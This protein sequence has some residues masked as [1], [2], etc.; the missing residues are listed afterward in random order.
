[1]KKNPNHLFYLFIILWL[2]LVPGCFKK[3]IT[4]SPPPLC[5]LSEHQLPEFEDDLDYD[6][7][8][9]GIRRSLDY[10][11]KL[12]EDR[13]FVFGTDIFHTYDMIRSL[14]YFAIYIQSHPSKAQLNRFI[15]NNYRIYR[16]TGGKKSKSVMFTGYYEPLLH[17]SL[18]P[19]K[20]F[21]YPLHALPSD[22][23][24]IDL[25]LF[26]N[27]FAGRKIFGRLSG[28]TVIPYYSRK[29]IELQN[30]LEQTSRP[31]VWV[32]SRIDLFFLQIQGSGK[33][34]LDNGQTLN[35]HYAGTNGHPYR[36]IGK[37]LI[38]TEKISEQEMSMQK[39]KSYLHQHPEEVQEIL[40][41][42]PSY[43]FFRIEDEG[44]IGCFNVP[45]T[46]KRSIAT[47]RRIFPAAALCF[48]QSRKP[49]LDHSQKIQKWIDFGRFVLNQDTGG[50]IR[51]P[52]RADIFWGNGTYA[53]I[54]AGHL[55]HDGSLYV[56][57]LNPSGH[58]EY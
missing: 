47:D 35:V 1:M 44:P 19:G 10:L 31:L 51:G 37:L 46:P 22:L 29:E 16:S 27:E 57:I 34:K 6:D 23:V 12:P 13:E 45:L 11:N 2:A 48:I 58:S 30:V 3:K 42:N 32:D 53:E 50:A 56:L 52:G 8:T 43:V 7:L 38:N 15:K 41:F 9:A 14:E 18:V 33:V 26:S 49:V 5:L 4:V 36:S 39:I 20:D 21:R 28:R 25:S 54:A 17:G 24:T 55:K 40:H